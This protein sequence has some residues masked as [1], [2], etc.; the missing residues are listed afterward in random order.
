M[1]LG[2]LTL[3]HRARNGL[4]DGDL[5]PRVLSA[6]SS[7]MTKKTCLA[8]ERLEFQRSPLHESTYCAAPGVRFQAR[9]MRVAIAKRFVWLISEIANVQC[10][11]HANQ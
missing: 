2:E 7:S 6:V 5:V 4:H 1:R 10:H 3:A 8:K 9:G 11:A